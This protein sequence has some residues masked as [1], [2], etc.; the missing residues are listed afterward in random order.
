MNVND[1]AITFVFVLIIVWYTW[2]NNIKNEK[3][4]YFLNIFYY[5]HIIININLIVFDI[6]LFLKK[7]KK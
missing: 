3:K 4:F 5:I 1:F 6:F 2:S 7:K